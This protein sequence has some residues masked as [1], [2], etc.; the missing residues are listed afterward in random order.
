MSHRN[1]VSLEFSSF[2]LYTEYVNRPVRVLRT[3]SRE[4]MTEIFYPHFLDVCICECAYLAV[5]TSQ[6]RH[7]LQSLGI[8]TT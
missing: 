2:I 5:Q 8:T 6:F 4:L 1:S 3:E 7:L